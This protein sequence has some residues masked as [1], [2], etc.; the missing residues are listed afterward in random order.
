MAGQFE[1]TQIAF[2][3]MLGSAEEANKL[4]GELSEFASR[5]PFTISGI[6]QNA[7]LLLGMG[8]AAEDMIPTL[9]A[10]G[11]VSAGLNVPMERIALNFGQVRVQ[12]KLTGREL[13]D[14]AIAG[15]PLVSELAKNLGIAEKEIAAMV[16]RG[17]IGFKEVEEAFVSMTSA[18]GRFANL[19]DESS[20]TFPGQISNIQDS[21]H[22]L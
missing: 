15:V 13:R 17:E 8:V 4:L 9:K 21:F 12:G 14:F 5:T 16:S 6:R 20:K 3:T 11:D 7:K 18:G 10:L 2:Q 19:M 1:Q 22:I